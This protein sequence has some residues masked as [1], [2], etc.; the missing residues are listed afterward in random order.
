MGVYNMEKFIREYLDYIIISEENEYGVDYIIRIN[1]E[2]IKYVFN[3]EGEY[4]SKGLVDS[5]EVFNSLYSDTRFILLVLKIIR[6]EILCVLFLL[7]LY[8][9]FTASKDMLR[10][11]FYNSSTINIMLILL[12]VFWLVR[13]SYKRGMYGK[14]I[15]N[16]YFNIALAVSSGLICVRLG[17]YGLFMKCLVIFLFSLHGISSTANFCGEM[18]LSEDYVEFKKRF[19]V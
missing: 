18:K 1:G 13:F 7:V 10:E 19:P 12:G 4:V 9:S 3:N 11:V 8:E 16:N 17:D 14:E 6:M 2:F 5:R 15:I